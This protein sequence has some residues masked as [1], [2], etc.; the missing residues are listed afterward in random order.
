MSLKPQPAKK[1]IRLLSTLGFTIARK[2]GSHVVMKHCD[3]RIAVIPVHAKEEIGT[4]LLMKIVKD[5]G[6][7][8]EEFI[9]LLKEV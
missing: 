4:G 1:I 7:S 9:R 2:R 8:K 5:T 3:G 6:L